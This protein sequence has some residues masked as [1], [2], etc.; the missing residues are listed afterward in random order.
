MLIM[1]I[2]TSNFPNIAY[3]FGFLCNNISLTKCRKEKSYAE[4]RY[5]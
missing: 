2:S 3:F 1:D 4:N 5:R